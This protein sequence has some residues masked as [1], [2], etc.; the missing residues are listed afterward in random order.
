MARH[1]NENIRKLCRCARSN[2][3]K[4]DHPWHFNFK[5][6]GKNGEIF[7]FSLARELDRPIKSKT[8]AQVARDEIKA[9]IRKGTF[10]RRGSEGVVDVAAMTVCDLMKL[11]G[12]RV[13]ATREKASIEA[14]EAHK[15]VIVRTEVPCPIGPPRPFGDWKIQDVTTDAIEQFRD[16]RKATGKV[17]AN[18]YLTTLQACFSWAASRKRGYVTE[19]PFRDGDKPAIERF[20]K[21]ARTRRL[22]AGEDDHLLTACGSDLRAIVECALETGM[23]RGEILSL[24]WWQVKFEPR[25]EI[26]LPAV[27]TKT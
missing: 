25:G 14:F 15:S 7:R 24:Q 18:R 22:E 27:K 8:E 1:K 17:A 5:L 13:V 26:F 12:E 21:H 20:A 23:R 3:P 10:R 19:S 2:W 9:A 16:V 11:Y 4:C 6:P